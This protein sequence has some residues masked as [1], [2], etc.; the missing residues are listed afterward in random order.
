MG[1]NYY[2][3]RLVVPE[4]TDIQWVSYYKDKDLVSYQDKTWYP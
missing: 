3:S 1:I 2:T 4:N